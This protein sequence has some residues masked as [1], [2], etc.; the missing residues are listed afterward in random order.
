MHADMRW[1]QVTKRLH[2]GATVSW[3]FLSTEEENKTLKNNNIFRR[4]GVSPGGCREPAATPA[5]GG[6]ALGRAAPIR[7][8]RPV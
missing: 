8:Y 4:I 6:F 1:A 7:R 3:F 5:P 2:F